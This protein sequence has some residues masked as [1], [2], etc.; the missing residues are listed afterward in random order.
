MLSV[1]LLPNTRLWP[2]WTIIPL[3]GNVWPQCMFS[4]EHCRHWENNYLSWDYFGAN[5]KNLLKSIFLSSCMYWIFD[6]LISCTLLSSVTVIPHLI[7]PY[8]ENIKKWH[9]LHLA[10]KKSSKHI[11]S[12]AKLK[13]CILTST[14][15]QSIIKL[16]LF[17]KWYKKI[18]LK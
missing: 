17:C 6:E 12:V 3:W 10:L 5:W 15:Q 1:W 18:V 7:E 16:I 11:Q 4:L 13:S 2:R 9:I 8:T 14:I